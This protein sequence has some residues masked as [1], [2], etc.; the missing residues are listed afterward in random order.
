MS[1]RYAEGT[2]VSVEKSQSEVT[3]ILRKYGANRF[4]TME[5]ESTAFLMFEFKGLSVQIAVPLPDISEYSKT[6]TGRIRAT[7]AAEEA[8][9]QAIKQRWRALVLAVKAKL[10]AV[11][12]GIST[13]EKEFLA[14]V[15][16][17]DGRQLSEHLIP[18]LQE[19]VASGNMPKLL[20]GPK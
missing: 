10:E 11:E 19:I 1:K 9:N 4:G 6:E 14:F 13:V 17:P 20:G 8:R 15:M 3:A 2:T 5:D 12:I 18:K 7:S 16:M